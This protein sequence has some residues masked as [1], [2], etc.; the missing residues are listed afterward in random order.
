M[1]LPSHIAVRAIAVA[2]ALLAWCL[3]LLSA[4]AA[5][6]A[7]ADDPV[8]LSREG[9]ITD[10]V[11][12]LGDRKDAT[13]RA[14]DQLYDDRGLQLFVVYV[15]DFSGRGSQDWADTTAERNGLGLDDVLLAVA[16]HDRQ[17]AYSVD[18]DSRLTEAQLQDVATTA[19]K[20]ALR[21][22]DWAGAAIGAANGYSAVLSGRP[23]PTPAIT[24]GAADPGGGGSGSGGE[25]A[26]GDL[27]LPIVVVG[28]AGA[29][30]AVAYSRRKR[31]TNTRTTPGGG[32][33]GKGAPGERPTPLPEL[34]KRSKQ[35]L[36]ETDDAIR[37]SAEELGFATAQF[38]DDAVRPFTDALAYARSELT[39]AFKLRQQLDDAYPED[40]ATKRTMLEEIVARCTD[41]GRRLDAEAAGFDQLRALERDVTGALD[42]AEQ[43]FREVTGRTTAA[44]TILGKIRDQYAPSAS[45]PVLGHVEQAKDRLL[46]A[47]THLNEARQAIDAG[48]NGKAAVHLRAAEGAVD[49]AA[50][51]VDAVDR[52]ADELAQAAEKLPAALTETETDLA[53]ARGLLEG[54]A[55]G[56]STADLHGRIA[57]AETV[58]TEVRK[59]M[60][61][62]PHDPIDAL[63]RVEEADTVLDE[64]L[65]GAREREV[66]RQRAA[67]LLGQALLT[68]RSA[69]G[70]AADFIDTHRGGVGSEART[71]LAEA[72]RHLSGAEAAKDTDASAAL[73]EAQQA[74]AQA[75]QAHQLAERDV[76]GYGNPYGGGGGRGGGMGGAVLGGII[77]GELFGG[78]GRGMGGGGFGGGGFGGGGPGSFGGGGTRGRMGGGGRF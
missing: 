2:G 6:A 59:K 8:T 4:P 22:N 7:P 74:D 5:L 68:A 18:V 67:T 26:T 60:A 77:L 49:Q 56:A 32:G 31:R 66:T 27:V 63:R 75:R 15:R 71:R 29:L 43:V 52:L 53:E 51:F 11:G 36:V 65:A 19:I 14:L 20:P 9:Q 78:G 1:T 54:T 57:R 33:W 17:Y 48:D 40:D 34:D 28:G 70:T 39:T 3:L 58:V 69:V 37:T 10:K 30:A 13:A 41:A 42:H 38:G 62:G 47:T 12:A 45:A 73:A 23:V 76:R 72:Q 16:T 55:A 61:A 21:Q 25:T 44:E 46:F 24:P 50:T 64:S 35:L